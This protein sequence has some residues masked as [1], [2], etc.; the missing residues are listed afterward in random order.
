VIVRGNKGARLLVAGALQSVGSTSEPVV[1]RRNAQDQWGGIVLVGELNQPTDE[2]SV[3]E[4]TTVE[5][6]DIGLLSRYDAPTFDNNFFAD[7]SVALDVVGPKNQALTISNSVIAD[8]A[9][10][11]TGRA[12]DEI[13]VFRNDFWNNGVSILAG[14]KR[15]FDCVPQG[16]GWEIHQND[17]LR[18]PQN[19]EYW[20]NDVHAPLGSNQSSYTVDASDNWWGTTDVNRII[21]RLSSRTACCPSPA[22]KVVLVSPLSS[23][24][25]TSWTPPGGVP[26]PDPTTSIH[27]DPSTVVSIDKPRNGACRSAATFRTVRGR[28]SSGVDQLKSVYVAFGRDLGKGFCAW[29]SVRTQTLRRGFCASPKW[30]RARGVDNWS[31]QFPHALTPGRFRVLAHGN[32]PGPATGEAGRSLVNFTLKG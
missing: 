7:N 11:L 14:P 5:F 12:T 21:G 3:I 18:G 9:V 28:G 30:F 32:G 20:S 2:R 8:N 17:I 27:H 16:G 24:P 19:S 4:N 6:A 31:Y 23:A 15:T 10:G 26:D 1:F 29:W 13:D 22:Q 25:N